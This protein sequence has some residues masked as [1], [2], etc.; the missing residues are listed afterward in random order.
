VI[1]RLKPGVTL[2]QAQA[3]LNAIV[4][5]LQQQFPQTNAVRSV[6]LVSLHER[7]VGD[8]R[9][10][11]LLL[12]GA[13]GLV[14]LIASAN[15]ANLM[16]V[17]AAGRS[18]EIAIRL[19]LGA[20]RWRIM[21]QLLTESILLACLGGA[22]GWLLAIWGIDL[23]LALSPDGTPRLSEVRLDYQVFAFTLLL[24]VMTGVVFGLF[25]ALAA[26]KADL[27]KP[28]KRAVEAQRPAV[29]DTV[30]VARW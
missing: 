6:R 15:V 4:A 12:F 22:C 14:L 21:R 19:A 26:S 30:C 27:I 24:S 11:M 17:R 1:G 8:S 13:V 3:D 29:D 5:R 2:A 28:S 25:P 18:Q 10:T 16:I 20:G 7:V 23:L 9:Q